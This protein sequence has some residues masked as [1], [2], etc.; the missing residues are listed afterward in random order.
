MDMDGFNSKIEIFFKFLPSCGWGEHS[1][2]LWHSVIGY[3][4]P[5][6]LRKYN[7]LI[8]KIQNIQEEPNT[9]QRKS[10]DVTLSSNNYMIEDKTILKNIFWQET[11]C[12]FSMIHITCVSQI[13][14]LWTFF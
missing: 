12:P 7:G 11:L 4:I 1:Y 14:I 10:W 5:S 2:E 9:Q 3:L 13:R 6:I 8:F